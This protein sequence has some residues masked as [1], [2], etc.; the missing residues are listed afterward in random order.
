[1]SETSSLSKAPVPAA[2]CSAGELAFQLK[3]LA[4]PAR[5][6]IIRQLQERGCCCCG[7]FCASLDLAQSTV[8]QHLDMLRKAGLV[9]YQPEGTR[10]RYRLNRK[11]FLAL[12]SAIGAVAAR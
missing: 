7:D 11:S 8:S 12:A 10:S 2:D 9:E 6:E 3:A 4:H 5:L 1:M